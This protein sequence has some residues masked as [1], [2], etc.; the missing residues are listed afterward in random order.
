MASQKS[1]LENF[2]KLILNAPIQSEIILANVMMDTYWLK[3][4]AKRI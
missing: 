3:I 1:F 2:K 4:N